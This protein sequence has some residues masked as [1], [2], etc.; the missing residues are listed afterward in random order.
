MPIIKLTTPKMMNPVERPAE[1]SRIFD[2]VI[3]LA[4]IPPP[5]SMAPNKPKA[6]IGL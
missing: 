5:I 4:K 1:T 6:K 3:N 2:I